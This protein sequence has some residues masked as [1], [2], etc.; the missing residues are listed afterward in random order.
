MMAQT[1]TGLR[2]ARSVTGLRPLRTTIGAM[3]L[4]LVVWAGTCAPRAET[5]ERATVYLFWGDGCP[6]CQDAKA[7]L[8]LLA[9][10]YSGWELRDYEI[11]YDEANAVRF[12]EM[13]AAHGFQ[14]T[15]IPTIIIGDRHWIGFSENLATDI[16]AALRLCLET[17]CDAV[18]FEPPRHTIDL[19][20]VGPVDVSAQSLWISTALISFVDGFG[21]DRVD[22]PLPFGCRIR[23]VRTQIA[24]RRFEHQGGSQRAFDQH[25]T[26]PSRMKITG[27]K[28]R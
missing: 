16:E 21:S 18:P 3:V 27:G 7:F 28:Y 13:A 25:L 10:R 14:P 1:G 6:H 23:F 22:D 17:G 12:G 19:P 26:A 15:G 20:L 24:I 2:P 4:S 9:D 8:N 5:T 11:W